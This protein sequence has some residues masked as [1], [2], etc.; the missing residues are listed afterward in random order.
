MDENKENLSEESTSSIT[1]ALEAGQEALDSGENLISAFE[2]LESKLHAV[3]SELYNQSQAS[4]E[5]P[6][7]PGDDVIDAEFEEAE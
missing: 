7:P 1:A 4:P 5:E 3:S 2:D 6:P